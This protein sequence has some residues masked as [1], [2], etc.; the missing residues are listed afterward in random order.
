MVFFS[1]DLSVNKLVSS[2]MI[3]GILLPIASLPSHLSSCRSKGNQ[4][5][6]LLPYSPRSQLPNYVEN[7]L[8]IH[9]GAQRKFGVY[10]RATRL[11]LSVA[12][13]ETQS[14][15]QKFIVRRRIIQH[16]FL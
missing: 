13:L 14:P 5:G 10:D 16:Y 3:M 15:T 2:D 11:R 8:S 9:L 7:C 12:W 4:K 6:T 1:V